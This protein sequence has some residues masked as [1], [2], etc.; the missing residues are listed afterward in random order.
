M[1]DLLRCRFN[2]RAANCLFENYVRGVT[3]RVVTR[4]LSARN[5]L[6]KTKLKSLLVKTLDEKKAP[7]LWFQGFDLFDVNVKTI[8]QSYVYQ[9][10]IFQLS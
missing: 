5:S 10:R 1:N 3:L 9:D 6:W 4:I 8:E 2:P 7:K